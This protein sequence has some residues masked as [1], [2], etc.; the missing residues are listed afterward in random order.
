MAYEIEA[1]LDAA[2]SALRDLRPGDQYEVVVAGGSKPLFVILDA[3]LEDSLIVHLAGCAPIR[4]YKSN[5]VSV[6]R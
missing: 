2:V 5:L 6:S 4:L 3:V 1:E